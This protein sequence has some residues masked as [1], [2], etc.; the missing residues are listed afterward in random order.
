LKKEYL[1]DYAFIHPITMK[2]V[3]L[4]L[5]DLILVK[6]Q[7]DLCFP[8]VCWPL[9]QLEKWQV[10]LSKPMLSLHGLQVRA[11]NDVNVKVFKLD[12]STCEK[13]E[14]VILSIVN[15]TDCLFNKTDRENNNDEEDSA[16][17]S[18]SSLVLGFL[19]EM[20]LNKYVLEN[21]QVNNRQKPFFC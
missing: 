18:E 19:K 6:Y 5:G 15:A 12:K 16:E 3:N 14:K 9:S 8:A 7:A 20:Y 4:K 1:F 17:S 21:Q 10:A 13:A 2:L 11:E